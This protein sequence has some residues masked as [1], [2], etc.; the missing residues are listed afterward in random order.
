[1][2]KDDFEHTSFKDLQ[3]MYTSRFGLSPVGSS[4]AKLIEALQENYLGGKRKNAGRKTNAHHGKPLRQRVGIRLSEQ[5]LEILEELKTQHSLDRTALIE[6][7]VRYFSEAPKQ[8]QKRFISK[9]EE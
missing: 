9:F 8:K 2:A 4:R 1:M 3:A 7:A 5:I 6:L